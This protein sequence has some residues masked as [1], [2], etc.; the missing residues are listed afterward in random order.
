MNVVAVTQARV[1]SS[2]LPAKIL[3]KVNRETLLEI[4]LKRILKAN[5]IGQLIVATTHEEG[6]QDILDICN[7]VD[8]GWFQGD[9][10][11]V[12]DRFYQAVKNQK[13]D[14]VIRLTSDC[15]LIDPKLIDQ[16]VEYTINE[17]LDYCSNG[18]EEAYPDGQDIEV[19]KF[20]ALEKAWKEATLNSEKEHVTPYIHKNSTFKGNTMFTA[21]MFPYTHNYNHIRLTV[22]EAND[23]DVIEK[24]ITD[25]GVEKTWLEYTNYYMNQNLASINGKIIRN[26]GYQKSL[27]ND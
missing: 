18:L 26:E 27:K 14:Y 21:K 1:G 9:L 12:L 22:D 13:P 6:V 4:H 3:K 2:R 23:F 15:P 10:N 8:V 25:L 20:S 11:N 16:V 19:F 7:Q 24:I 17:N 5:K